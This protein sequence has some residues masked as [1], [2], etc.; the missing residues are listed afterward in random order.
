MQSATL[1]TYPR[2]ETLHYLC[3]RLLL[4]LMDLPS[5]W[6][7]RFCVPGEVLHF[8]LVLLHFYPCCLINFELKSCPGAWSSFWKACRLT[9]SSAVYDAQGKYFVRWWKWVTY[10]WCSPLQP[11]FV[12]CGRGLIWAIQVSS[13]ALTPRH[14]VSLWRQWTCNS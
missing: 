8:V 10:K 11:F 7:L 4:F 13:A 2:P 12:R 14:E 3:V 5:C 9:I 1:L 6:Q